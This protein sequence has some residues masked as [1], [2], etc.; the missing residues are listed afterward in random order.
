MVVACSEIALD[1]VENKIDLRVVRGTFEALSGSL[2]VMDTLVA[3]NWYWVKCD[4]VYR[5]VF[6]TFVN[7]LMIDLAYR[8]VTAVGVWARNWVH[9]PLIT[10]SMLLY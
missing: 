3:S 8:V 5:L 4:L 9:F 10:F 2:I 6:E 1:L 7:G